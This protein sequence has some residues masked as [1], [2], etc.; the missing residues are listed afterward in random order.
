MSINSP[1]FSPDTGSGDSYVK[2]QTV[3]NLGNDSF[4]KP[5]TRLYRHDSVYISYFVRK[6]NAVPCNAVKQEKLQ[7]SHTNHALQLRSNILT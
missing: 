7:E 1:A 2:D 4:F 3:L 5:D 6:T